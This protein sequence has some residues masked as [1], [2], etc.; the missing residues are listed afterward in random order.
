MKIAKLMTAF[1]AMLWTVPT[2]GQIVP[3][4][5]AVTDQDTAARLAVVERH[6]EAYRSGNLDRFMATFAPNAEVYA[7]DMVAVGRDQ[8]RSF[9][10]ANFT[11][12]APR[13]RQLS[14][15]AAGEF[16]FVTVGF[17]SPAG[18]QLFCSFTEYGVTGDKISYV[19]SS[20]TQCP[21]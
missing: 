12:S 7:H 8:I 6:V 9:Y 10:R 13:T 11:P 19:A 3:Q 17:Y 18:Q 4:D 21:E 2:M 16:V 5:V 1:A 15:E 20:L 14:S